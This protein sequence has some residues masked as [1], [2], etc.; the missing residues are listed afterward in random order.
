MEVRSQNRAVATK[1]VNRFLRLRVLAFLLRR[2][3][4]KKLIS[5]FVP[6]KNNYLQHREYMKKQRI[7]L[8]ACKIQKIAR[9]VAAREYVIGV[10]ERGK[11]QALYRS[12]LKIQALFRGRLQRWRWL[13]RK[14]KIHDIKMAIVCQRVY[15]GYTARKSTRKMMMV[16][17]RNKAAIKIQHMVLI[18]QAKRKVS[19]VREKK[20][21]ERAATVIQKRIRGRLTRKNMLKIIRD[22]AK[23]LKIV[24]IQKRVRGMIARLN[25]EKRKMKIIREKEFRLNSVVNIQRSPHSIYFFLSFALFL[26][27]LFIL[28]FSF[29]L[30]TFILFL[31]NVSQ[32]L[33]RV[34]W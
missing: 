30:L 4:L 34:S 17:W 31:S 16:I 18:K 8:A 27:Y 20:K 25:L 33:S 19:A 9:G 15:R 28:W 2:I 5:K 14:K 3:L 22:K 21:M 12:T 6:W 24:L 11:Y 13:K 10:R 1:N 26:L 29:L 32:C 23:L 7:N